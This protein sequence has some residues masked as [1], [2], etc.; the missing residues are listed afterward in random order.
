MRRGLQLSI[1]LALALGLWLRPEAVPARPAEPAQLRNAAS[2]A[3]KVRVERQAKAFPRAFFLQAT[4][5]DRGVALTFDGCHG[6][7]A[8]EQILDILA[9]AEVPA[10]FFLIGEPAAR[11]PDL[12]RA[13][14][15]RGHAIGGHGYTHVFLDKLGV[16]EAYK[17]QI[18]ATQCVFEE[19]LGQKP[20]FYR[21]PYGAVTDEQI[22]YFAKR[23]MVTVN[24]SVDSLDWKREHRNPK[25][26]AKSVLDNVHDG[27]IV[28]FHCVGAKKGTI[29]AL[30]RIIAALKQRGYALRTIPDLLALEQRE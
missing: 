18:L 30:A 11:R 19:I 6:R 29:P 25:A 1:A 12:V 13:I 20:G 5:P 24:W 28:L 21:P 27:A 3:F 7:A 4:A 26:I 22:A 23:G 10:T 14:H 15:E 17:K 2:R 16:E 8:T 9:E